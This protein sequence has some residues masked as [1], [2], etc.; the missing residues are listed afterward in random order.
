MSYT[1]DMT[2]YTI[3]KIIRAHLTEIAALQEQFLKMRYDQDST[4]SI[5]GKIKIVT[6]TP[7]G[8]REFDLF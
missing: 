8:S 4:I 6:N 3:L 5:R 2:L 1:S 7:L